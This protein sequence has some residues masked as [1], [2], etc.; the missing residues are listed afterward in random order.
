MNDRINDITS[1]IERD[2][3]TLEPSLIAIRRDIH[4]H[5]E[6]GHDT[7]RTAALVTRE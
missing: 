7:P 6:L 3:A 1:L 2:T 5:P 4:A